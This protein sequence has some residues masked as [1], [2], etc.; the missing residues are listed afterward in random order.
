M[1][2]KKPA[3]VQP[4]TPNGKRTIVQQIENKTSAFPL[5]EFAV[6]YGID[7]VTAWD[8]AR[9]GRLPAIKIGNSWRLDPATTV[10]WLRQRTSA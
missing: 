9:T 10:E 7:Y 3:A 4:G 8:M 6:M 1:P 2:R 5:K